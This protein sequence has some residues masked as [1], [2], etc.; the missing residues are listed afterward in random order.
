MK[1]LCFFAGSWPQCHE[2]SAA[3]GQG[4]SAVCPG[5]QNLATCQEVDSLLAGLQH[6]WHALHQHPQACSVLGLLPDSFA[7]SPNQS[8]ES[9]MPGSP[10]GLHGP[11]VPTTQQWQQHQQQL[12]LRCAHSYCS[13]QSM[14]AGNNLLCRH[15]ALAAGDQAQSTMSVTGSQKPQSPHESAMLTADLVSPAVQQETSL[16]QQLI[17]HQQSELAKKLEDA[18]LLSTEVPEAAA[19]GSWL[20]GS[21]IANAQRLWQHLIYDTQVVRT[22]LLVTQVQCVPN[23]LSA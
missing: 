21:M 16:Q 20:V 13:Q 12:L 6:S 19:D 15:E 4:P 8:Q 10:T 11:S 5:P 22:P 2:Q 18:A 9:L 14:Q 7:C 3:S 1:S 23:Q 17:S